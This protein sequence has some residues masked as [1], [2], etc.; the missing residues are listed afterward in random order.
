M[1]QFRVAWVLA[2]ALIYSSAAFQRGRWRRSDSFSTFFLI[3]RST[4]PLSFFFPRSSPNYSALGC[5]FYF[6]Y[7]PDLSRNT[8]VPVPRFAL[9]DKP[10]SQSLR[11]AHRAEFNR[12]FSHDKWNCSKARTA[13]SLACSDRSSSLRQLI[14]CLHDDIA[15]MLQMGNTYHSVHNVTIRLWI[16]G[17]MFNQGIWEIGQ[18]IE[19]YALPLLKFNIHWCIEFNIHY[20][21]F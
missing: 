16:C 13:G 9:L 3:F 17:E 6:L 10:S 5:L 14:I 2:S 7:L 12:Y 18:S 15:W 8:T 19:K 4:L 21:L 1:V 20:F 11:H